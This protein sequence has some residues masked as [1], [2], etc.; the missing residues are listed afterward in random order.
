MGDKVNIISVGT[1]TNDTAYFNQQL[2]TIGWSVNDYDAMLHWFFVDTQVYSISKFQTLNKAYPTFQRRWAGGQYTL[3]LLRFFK[4]TIHYWLCIVCWFAL[5]LFYFKSSKKHQV[6]LIFHF[7]YIVGFMFFMFYYLKLEA[8]IFTPIVFALISITFFYDY[9]TPLFKGSKW[10]KQIFVLFLSLS[11]VAYSVKGF[12]TYSQ[13]KKNQE[14]LQ[15]ILSEQPTHHKNISL[16]Y[17]FPF[18]D[19]VPLQNCNYL[20]KANIIPISTL[21]CS[22]LFHQSY[23]RHGIND[24]LKF[25]G[26]GK[27]YTF[28]VFNGNGIHTIE[29]YYYE[30]YHISLKFVKIN[31]VGNCY[32]YKPVVT[33]ALN[34]IAL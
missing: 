4:E 30:H 34:S 10:V 22:P 25:I 28:W 11:V 17:G 19:L 29:T 9:Q 5:L 27:D 21:V 3:K 6:F 12:K 33:P 26:D 20:L 1:L 15:S 24:I 23:Q 13:A 31:E 32:L 8:R 14:K 18:N 7:L 16:S 2:K